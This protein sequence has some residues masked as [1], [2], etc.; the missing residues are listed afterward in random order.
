MNIIYM[1]VFSRLQ[2]PAENRCIFLFVIC[3]ETIPIG[4]L[5][6]HYDKD[7]LMCT[8]DAD[9]GMLQLPALM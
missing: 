5:A 4:R 8:L 6:A 3:A 1:C 7:K 9:S 2:N